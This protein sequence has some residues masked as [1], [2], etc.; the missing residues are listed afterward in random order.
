MDDCG[1]VEFLKI[2]GKLDLVVDNTREKHVES[3]L[4]LSEVFSNPERNSNT[5]CSKV[6]RCNREV[7][8][9]VITS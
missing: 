4:K 2:V 1:N 6:N 7:V 3:A 8:A 5:I 9:F